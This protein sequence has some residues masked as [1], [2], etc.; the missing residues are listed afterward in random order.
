MIAYVYICI[1]TSTSTSTYTQKAIHH[2]HR[3]PNELEDLFG[4]QISHV[5]LGLSSLYFPHLIYLP[6]KIHIYLVNHP[7]K[8]PLN[9]HS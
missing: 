9:H 6:S 1:Y 3:N 8:S 5:L 7:K 2:F 4:G